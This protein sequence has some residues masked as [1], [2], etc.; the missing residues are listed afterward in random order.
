MSWSL[1]EVG[2]ALADVLGAAID[3]PT[4]ASPPST[5][6]PPALVVSYPEL[7]DL[8]SRA[9]GLDTATIPVVALVGLSAPLS[10]LEA[11]INGVVSVIGANRTLS[12]AVANAYVDTVR[13]IR[14]A[15][16]AGVD[17]LAADLVVMV[18]S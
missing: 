12:S 18:D 7:V 10:D 5:L 15:Q 17:V 4:F 14:S 3:V 1:V 16:V 6:N 2:E 8:G 9:L 11:L 13:S